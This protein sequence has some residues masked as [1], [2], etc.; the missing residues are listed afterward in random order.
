MIGSSFDWA[1]GMILTFS[2]VTNW[3]AIAIVFIA[4]ASGAAIPR[5]HAH[6]AFAQFTKAAGP[7]VVTVFTTDSP[8]RAGPVDISLLIQSREDQQPVLDCVALLQLWKNDATSISSEATHQGAQNKL[9]YAAQV[10]L[11][12]PG[13]WELEAV[14]THENDSVEVGGSITVVPSNPVF[15]AYWRSLTLP[16]LLITLFALNQWLK[17]RSLNFPLA[18]PV[19]AALRGR[20]SVRR[21]RASI[22]VNVKGVRS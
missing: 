12:E 8:L 19:G 7:F 13:V 3:A 1:R 9:L 22:R 17:R 10:K 15:L 11:P 18:E 14:I 16:P 6:G 21:S 5:A 2:K 4:I 20:P